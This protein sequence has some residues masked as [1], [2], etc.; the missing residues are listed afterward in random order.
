MQ[1]DFEKLVSPQLREIVN[2]GGFPKLAAQMY[3][4]QDDSERTLLMHLGM[5]IAMQRAERRIIQAGLQ[6]LKDLGGQA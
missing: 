2:T 6:A 5:K 3:G 4:L 1:I